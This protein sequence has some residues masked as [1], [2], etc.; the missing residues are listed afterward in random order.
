[1]SEFSVDVFPTN[2]KV[3]PGLRGYR[4]TILSKQAADNVLFQEFLMCL[5]H[6]IDIW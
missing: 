1:M 4:L 2:G 5:S 6:K 3:R